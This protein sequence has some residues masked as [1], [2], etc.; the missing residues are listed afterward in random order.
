MCVVFF[1]RF[2][3]F[4]LFFFF[5]TI[6]SCFIPLSF[7]II[8]TIITIITHNSLSLFPSLSHPHI[9][10]FS[11]PLLLLPQAEILV[12]HRLVAPPRSSLVWSWLC[13]SLPGSHLGPLLVFCLERRPVYSPL[14][15][16][17][18]RNARATKAS[19]VWFWFRF[20][21]VDRPPV[22]SSSKQVRRA[23]CDPAQASALSRFPFQS[24]PLLASSSCGTNP[25]RLLSN[26]L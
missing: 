15:I 8:I 24:L 4:S 11:L 25:L 10:S 13:A 3:S 18:R 7:I 19:K 21:S 26:H 14:P 1:L 2:T 6:P 9:I 20:P 5:L 23:L 12:G 17:T 16:T 22:S